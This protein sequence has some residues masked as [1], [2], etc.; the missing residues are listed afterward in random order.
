MVAEMVIAIA[1]ADIERHSAEKFSQV[2][3]NVCAATQYEILLSGK[4]FF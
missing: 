2:R 1:Y 3:I 4:T